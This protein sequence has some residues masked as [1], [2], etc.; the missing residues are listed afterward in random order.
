MKKLFIFICFFVSICPVLAKAESVELEEEFLKGVYFIITLGDETIV[1]NHEAIFRLNGKIAYCLEPG[2]VAKSGYYQ[3]TK[4]LSGSYLSEEKQR[5]IEEIGYY[6]YEYPGHQQREY[7]LAAQELI[8][9]TV[10]SYEIKWMT[11]LN[12]GTQIDVE[13]EKKE[14]LRLME[15]NKKCPS[16]HL[17]TIYVYEDEFLELYDHNM[18]IEKYEVLNPHF[19]VIDQRLVGQGFKGPMKV[20]GRM[21]LYD[22]EGTLLYYQEHSQKMATLRLSDIATFELSI[23]VK[24]VSMKIHKVGEVWN[25]IW[26]TGELEKQTGVEFEL[27]AEEDIMGHFDN[28]IYSKGELIETLITENGYAETKKLPNGKYRLVETKPN[29][30]Y[31]C[32]EPVIFEINEFV[33]KDSILEIKNELS[34]GTL[35]IL[36]I[37]E[38]GFPLTDVVFGLYSKSGEKLDERITGQDGKIVWEQLPVGEYQIQEL[39]AKDGYI[40]DTTK[41]KVKI[42]ENQNTILERVNVPLLPNTSE[43]KGSF[44]ILFG[45]FVLIISNQLLR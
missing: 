26:N 19:R 17:D 11:N 12:N 4:G 38:A 36:K 6:G 33:E 23:V 9:E 43:R 34:T 31:K 42:K 22:K 41:E 28:V 8:W 1:K 3:V 15:E 30:G 32:S 21:K 10:S 16:F 35:E 40:L 25:G 13:K 27:Y 5:R 2:V 20:E 37:D 29:D 24:G 45:L 7:Y 14:I 44:Q 18:V 39:K